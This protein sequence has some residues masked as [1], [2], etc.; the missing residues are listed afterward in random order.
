MQG[1][2]GDADIRNRLVDTVGEDREGQIERVALKHAV[3]H[4][5]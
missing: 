2:R 1:S 4:V 5:K 3:H